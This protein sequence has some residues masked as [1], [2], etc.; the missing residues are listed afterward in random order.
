MMAVLGFEGQYPL[1]LGNEY[2]RIEIMKFLALNWLQSLGVLLVAFV[3]GGCT[4]IT[5]DPECPSTLRVGDL[6]MVLANEMNPGAIAR[7]RWEVMP[8]DAGEFTDPTDP[9]TMFQALREVDAML[10]LTASDGLYQVIADCTVLIR[11]V[12]EVAVTLRA[13]PV[14][15]EVDEVVTL[16]CGSVGESEATARIITFEDGPEIV[17]PVPG[18]LGVARFEPGRPGEYTFRCVGRNEAGTESQPV[19]IS[20]LVSRASDNGNGNANDND[21]GT[22]N[23]NENGNDNAGSESSDGDNSNGS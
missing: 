1:H 23:D 4:S 18:S 19:E 3:V 22:A 16:T 12:A 7:Y 11:G 17:M 5:V 15:P 10:R 20:I 9:D 13:D 6:G 2:R 14:D 21:N 8:A